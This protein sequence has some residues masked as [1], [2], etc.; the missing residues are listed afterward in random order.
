MARWGIAATRLLVAK[1]EAERV[2]AFIEQQGGCRATYYNHAKKLGRP[3]KLPDIQLDNPP[4]DPTPHAV[5][6][7][8]LL[9]RRGRILGSDNGNQ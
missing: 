9:R 8:E 4:P 7:L 6:L 3:L 2:R 5:S 1:P